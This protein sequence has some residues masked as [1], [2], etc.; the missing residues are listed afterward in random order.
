MAGGVRA[1]ASGPTAAP[2]LALAL[3]VLAASAGCTS[4]READPTGLLGGGD[5]PAPGQVADPADADAPYPNLS[6]VPLTPPRRP[7]TRDRR[8]AIKQGL[9]GDRG[10]AN[11]SDEPPR[12]RP[13]EAEETAP[14]QT[15]AAGAGVPEPPA[16]PR[17]AAARPAASAPPVANRP[18]PESK[19]EA[20]SEPEAGGQP[21]AE[22]Q[23]EAER[24]PE[25]ESEAP[26]ETQTA[27]RPPA[28]APAWPLRLRFEAGAAEVTPEHRRRL[29]AL[30]RYLRQE[31]GPR[32]AIRA[33]AEPVGEDASRA[34]RLSL[35]RALAVRNVLTA[36]GLAAT[37]MDVR[38][39]GASGESGPLDRVDI[40][41]SKQ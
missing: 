35:R 23:P 20:E 22:S 41:L 6:S 10:R 29:A 30:A 14:A 17:L 33:Y 32:I 3:V 13:A 8:Q 21:E 18:P 36:E 28:S 4:V 31:S 38:A 25:G 15:A 24:Q 12:S 2:A 1:S 39:L 27:S 26:Q 19:P 5:S 7:S 40:G 9:I 34:R 11:Y 16:P 37:R